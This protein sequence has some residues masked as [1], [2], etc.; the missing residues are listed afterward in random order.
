MPKSFA[1][2]LGLFKQAA[3]RE[4]AVA[5]GEPA[6]LGDSK[7]APQVVPGGV[8]KCKIAHC[9]NEYA[10]LRDLRQHMRVEHST[11]GGISLFKNA[12]TRSD[13]PAG[14][15]AAAAAESA[16]SAAGGG[17]GERRKSNTSSLAGSVV[18]NSSLQ[19]D[20]R[21]QKRD[22]DDDDDEDDTDVPGS[23]QSINSTPSDGGSG[24]SV[25]SSGSVQEDDSSEHKSSSS[26]S[27]SSVSKSG[28]GGGFTLSAASLA[29]AGSAPV[30]TTTSHLVSAATVSAPV[31]FS[32][33]ASV[34][35]GN[36]YDEEEFTY[37]SELANHKFNI[38][39][40]QVTPEPFPEPEDFKRSVVITPVEPPPE[41]ATRFAARSSIKRPDS[42]TVS[43]RIQQRLQRT[44][45]PSPVASPS[46]PNL[47]SLPS[48]TSTAR[49]IP[50]PSA[51]IRQVNV[52]DP[53]Y[54]EI[55]SGDT[56][57]TTAVLSSSP[58]ANAGGSML[59]SVMME[60]QY[61]YGTRLSMHFMGSRDRLDHTDDEDDIFDDPDNPTSDSLLQ[62]FASAGFAA[63]ANPTRRP[64]MPVAVDTPSTAGDE[65]DSQKPD[66]LA[67]PSQESTRQRFVRF[68][69]Q[70]TQGDTHLKKRYKRSYPSREP[71]QKQLEKM[72]AEVRALNVEL[73]VAPAEY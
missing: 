39:Y 36:I 45:S 60:N 15:A 11:D 28:G 66:F 4:E 26:N 52:N 3:A 2:R 68:N 55:V 32:S 40:G 16:A 37:P 50:A 64:T 41:F 1:E 62:Y 49:V 34:Y 18:E 51:K 73:G 13:T 67:P 6:N 54:A 27:S 9:A 10:Y 7:E 56:T 31:G 59:S 35:R 53:E 69:P 30:V 44:A 21:S 17:G 23:R 72:E 29:M 38:H 63:R 24:G 48:T 14:I 5:N 47:D 65:V 25:V 8:Y 42:P 20:S 22:E 71:T 19:G 70:V 33:Q 61:G 43:Q 46:T 58:G 57:I 12:V